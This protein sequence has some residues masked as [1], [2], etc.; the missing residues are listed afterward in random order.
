MHWGLWGVSP[1]GHAKL[2]NCNQI[3]DRIADQNYIA[4][5]MHFSRM[6]TA[7]LMTVSQH[8]M[9]RGEVCIPAWTGWGCVCPGGVCQGG[10]VVCPGCVCVADT[11]LWAEWQTGVK[12]LPCHNF[13]AGGNYWFGSGVMHRGR[14]IETTREHFEIAWDNRFYSLIVTTHFLWISGSA[15]A[16]LH[17]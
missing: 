14:L 15:T 5:S 12:T 2:L 7:H 17:S 4:T 1:L 10:V 3:L 11:P 16:K 6:R 8:A 13:V 9:C